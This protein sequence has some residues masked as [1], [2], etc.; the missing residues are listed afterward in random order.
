MALA[1]VNFQAVP[2]Q[3]D[4]VRQDGGS[5]G[6]PDRAPHGVPLMLSKTVG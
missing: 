4:I 1:R 3:G 6:N 5:F 2:K